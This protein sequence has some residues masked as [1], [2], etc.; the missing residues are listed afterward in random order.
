MRTE[1]QHVEM[2]EL[3][4][5]LQ[6]LDNEAHLIGQ[7]I[8]DTTARSARAAQDF[9]TKRPKEEAKVAA[10][11]QETADITCNLDRVWAETEQTKQRISILEDQITN[12]KASPPRSA[13]AMMIGSHPLHFT[14]HAMT[15][16]M[17][18]SLTAR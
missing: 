14:R 7:Q 15:N 10:A 1:Q 9:E 18:C 13:R 8:E 5:Q 3:K 12:D 17:S 6:L 4:S 2:E 16:V 11:K